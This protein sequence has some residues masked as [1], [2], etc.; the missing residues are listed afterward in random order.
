MPDYY[1]VRADECALCEVASRSGC[2]CGSLP[3]GSAS[4]ISTHI[5]AMRSGKREARSEAASRPPL[6]VLDNRSCVT[7]TVAITTTTPTIESSIR[8]IGTRLHRKFFRE[9][10]SRK[11]SMLPA[12]QY[13]EPT[14]AVSTGRIRT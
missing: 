12:G 11:F 3:L 8:N 1:D 14:G 10:F 13:A 7:V 2:L 6:H 4:L 5:E 9:K